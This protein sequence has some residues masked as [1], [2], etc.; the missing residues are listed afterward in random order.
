MKIDIIYRCCENEMTPQTFKH[1]RPNWFNKLNCLKTFL[2]TI[3]VCSDVINKV[4]FVHDGP[5]GKLFKDIPK[6]H[7]VIEINYQ[8]NELC[9]LETF[10]LANNLNEHLYFV[11]DDYLHL[12]NSIK[13]I[14]YGVQNFKLVTGYDHLDR[15][16]RTDDISFG[17]ES[18]A[19]SKKT[20]CHWRTAESTCC[21][22]A[23]TRQLW[24]NTMYAYATKYKL[25]DRELFRSL[26]I[27]Q[28]IRLW[29]PIPGVTTQV[30]CNLSPGINWENV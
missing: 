24:N 28:N 9:L 20:N 29:T 26:N 21:T 11:E 12:P 1:F 23:C 10:K 22:W 4:Y 5:K 8:N 14:Y 17:K 6:K 30:D 16:T 15:Y 18:I 13:T 25:Q 19:F 7:E 2:T 27:E 3:E